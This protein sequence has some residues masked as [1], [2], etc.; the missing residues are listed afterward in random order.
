MGSQLIT[1]NIS[2]TVF[3]DE[4]NQML[5]DAVQGRYNK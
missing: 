3:Y 1:C 5:I 4:L 2:Y